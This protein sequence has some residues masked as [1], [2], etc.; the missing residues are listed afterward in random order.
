[1]AKSVW[2]HINQPYGGANVT[3]YCKQEKCWTAFLE[4]NVYISAAVWDETLPGTNGRTLRGRATP[5]AVADQENVQRIKA[6][7]SD[8]WFAIH[9]W[10]KNSGVLNN[11]QLSTI[12]DLAAATNSG[13]TLNTRKANEG[14][15]ILEAVAAR[16]YRLTI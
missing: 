8:Q 10:A 3:Q 13:D 4:R 1:M 2:S 15:K 6:I 11:Y 14:I 9:T 12:L 7:K 5:Q 16:G